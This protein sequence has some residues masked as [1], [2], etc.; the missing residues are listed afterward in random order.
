M[1][2]YHELH[3]QIDFISNVNNK[4]WLDWKLKVEKLKND[5]RRLSVSTV[6]YLTTRQ[7]FRRIIWA[8]STAV[9]YLVVVVQNETVLFVELSKKLELK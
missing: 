1:A 2:L 7:N 8:I 9:G 3:I 6:Q 4:F 5:K